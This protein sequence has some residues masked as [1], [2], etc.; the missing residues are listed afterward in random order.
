MTA[1]SVA[2]RM[3]LQMAILA[4]LYISA[5]LLMAAKYLPDDTLV[6]ALPY[7][8]VSALSHV[9]LELA[10][11]CGLLGAGVY[12]AI[13]GQSVRLKWTY[14]AWTLFLIITCLIGALDWLEGRYMLEIPPILDLA[15][16]AL[17]IAFMVQVAQGNN[18]EAGQGKYVWLVGIGFILAAYIVSLIPLS[19]ILVDRILRVFTVQMRFN[20]GYVLA[21]LAVIYWWPRQ[22][23]IYLTGGIAVLIGT[24]V[25]LSP[26]AAIGQSRLADW[27]VAIV[28]LIAWV[29]FIRELTKPDNTP[30]RWVTFGLLLL[31]F[32]LGLLGGLI[33][34]QRIAAFTQGTLLTSLQLYLTMLSILIITMGF[35]RQSMTNTR[36]ALGFWL[37]VLGV[38]GGSLALLVAAGIQ[39]VME[40]M[41]SIGYLDVQNALVPFYGLWIIGLLVMGIGF[42]W[43]LL[44]MTLTEN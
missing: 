43:L 24:L 42:V 33:S 40:R 12:A 38:V 29:L 27:L 37:V 10:L 28:L 8:Q 18:I 9:L 2:S 30:Q 20:V 32:G 39:T 13:D 41:L 26:L 16:I 31:T 15:L 23:N 17:L 22:M 35:A 19:S 1:K 14:R 44:T 6:N 34:F 7:S 3:M 11:L 25:S 21:T 5:L 36:S 4:V